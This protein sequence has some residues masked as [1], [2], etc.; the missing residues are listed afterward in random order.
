LIE[1]FG[2][3]TVTRT[4]KPWRKDRWNLQDAILKT[5]ALWGSSF[6]GIGIVEDEKN[7][8]R[9]IVT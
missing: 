8:S 9:N 3:W 4:K 5:H 6:F 7:G 2:S 1:D